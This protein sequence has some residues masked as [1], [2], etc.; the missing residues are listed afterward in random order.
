MNRHRDDWNNER[1]TEPRDRPAPGRAR[2]VLGSFW[3][4]L[5]I[6]FVT[7]GLVLAFVAKPY[8]V[9]SE[10][11]EATL[12]PGDRVLVNRLAYRLGEPAPGDVVV[13]DADSAWD[14]VEPAEPTGLRA[15]WLWLGAW[16]GFGPSGAHT[17]VKRV[18]ATPGQVASCCSADGHVVVD[19]Q[20]LDEPYV[21]NDLPFLP[22]TLDC[23]TTPRSQRCFDEVT[24][25]Q[26]SYLML[27]DNRSASSDSAYNCRGESADN[28][29]C[30]RW[31][32]R[33]GIVGKVVAVVWP[34]T[35]WGV[36]LDP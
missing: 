20:P 29:T 17:L 4:Q 11:M 5:V 32:T 36:R 14:S 24:V 7:F 34:V 25:P 10:S 22:G 27:G 1:V 21:A 30:W 18:V 3:G 2:R 33:T 8:R 9:P 13:F 28:D 16:T 31:A 15:V 6:A 12:Q 26:D 19:A 35:R 23:T